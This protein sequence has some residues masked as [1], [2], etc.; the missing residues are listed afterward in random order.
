MREISAAN[1]CDRCGATSTAQ[2]Q[3]LAVFGLCLEC[4]VAAAREHFA[5]QGGVLDV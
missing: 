2:Q 5:S 1:P 4:S 3:G